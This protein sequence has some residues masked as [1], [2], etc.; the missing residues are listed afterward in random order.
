MEEQDFEKLN[1]HLPALYHYGSRPA[2]R[3][4]LRD[5]SHGHF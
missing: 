4:A 3:P 2:R 1:L 5:E